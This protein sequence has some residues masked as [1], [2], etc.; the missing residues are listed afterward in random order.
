MKILTFKDW[1]MI[2]EC[3]KAAFETTRGCR[4][5]VTAEYN[6]IRDLIRSHKKN[7]KFSGWENAALLICATQRNYGTRRCSDWR[8]CIEVVPVHPVM[9]KETKQ[10][11]Y[12]IKKERIIAVVNRR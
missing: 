8:K 9:Y 1:E 5:A 7:R 3:G 11:V 2:E 4:N 12:G 10:F 6:V